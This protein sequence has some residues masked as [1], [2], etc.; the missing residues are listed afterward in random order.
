M[1]DEGKSADPAALRLATIV[2][3]GQN[4]LDKA[5][6]YLNKLDRRRGSLR[7]R[8]GLGQPDPRRA[9]LEQGPTGRPGSG[10]SGWSSRT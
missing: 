8:Q 10:T 5:D 9:A 7:E 6:E 3:L 2:S 1:S 4:R